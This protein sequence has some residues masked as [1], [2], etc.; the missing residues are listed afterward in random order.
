MGSIRKVSVYLVQKYFLHDCST[1]S[2]SCS[3]RRKTGMRWQQYQ[4][5][6]ETRQRRDSVTVSNARAKILTQE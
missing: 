4:N 3:E 2:L 1:D 5:E 6:T